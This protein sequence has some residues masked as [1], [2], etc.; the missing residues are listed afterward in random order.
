MSDDAMNTTRG[1][2]PQLPR[3]LE[4]L[5]IFSFLENIADTLLSSTSRFLVLTA[6]TAAGKSTA[7][8][9]IFLDKLPGK[10]LMLE[11]RRVAAL[12]IAERLS[13]LLGQNCGETVGYRMRMDSRVSECTRLEVITEALLTR[14]IQGDP[15]LS[16]V[17]LVILDEFHERSVQGDLAL[18]LLR[19]VASLRDDLYVLI[20]SATIDTDQ[21]SQFLSAPVLT[22][23]GRTWPVE[24]A[25]DGS[26]TVP[27]AVMRELERGPGDLLV[28]LPGLFEIRSA[29]RTLGDLIGSDVELLVLHSSVSLSDQRA[30][31]HGSGNK[32]RV[33]LSSAIAETSLTVPGVT[34][35][36]DSGLS[37]ISRF[38]VRTGMDRLV[39]VPESV[40]SATQRAGR[41]GRTAPGRALRLWDAHDRRP[42]SLSTEIERTDIIPLV[43]D[44]ALWGVTRYDGLQWLTPPQ[45][46]AWEQ[47]VGILHWMGAL[48]NER[49]IT[50]R[51]RTMLNLGVHPRLA[52]VA[53][54]G[55]IEL[56]VAHAGYSENS[57]E[58][59]R[60]RA[61]LQRR[62]QREGH[63]VQQLKTGPGER[64]MALLSGFP[65]RL[66]LHRGDGVY[67]FPS[68]RLAALPTTD[69]RSVAVLPRW[70]VAT[71]VDAGEREG[72]IRTFSE[73][74]TMLCEQWLSDKLERKTEITM[75][76]PA[77]VKTERYYYDRLIVSERRLKVETA[78]RA[79]ALCALLRRDGLKLI[80][81]EKTVQS[82]LQRARFYWHGKKDNPVSENNLLA[83]LEEWL[84]PFLDS[85][86]N[87][88][89]EAQTV[90]QALRYRC[91]GTM[92]DGEVPSRITLANGLSR[93]LEYQEF[94]AD[95]GPVPV[96]E[97]RVQDLFGCPET[98]RVHGRPVLL[99]LLSP[100]RR[101]LQITSDLQGFWKNSWSEVVKE[102]KGRYPRHDWPSD[103]GK[104]QPPLNARKPPSHN[105]GSN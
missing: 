65:D 21:L 87:G 11:P 22:V 40:F 89:P 9:L 7:V 68:G 96:L 28:F 12:A 75:N 46:A 37:R 56:A 14:R 41:A 57:R 27:N 82:F 48:D 58:K 34:V 85:S 35:V 16:G 55:E 8:P 3:E 88:L 45:E 19:E 70:I 51:G 98:P 77:A 71:E 79:A 100:A 95:E 102:M 104:A 5:P 10:I 50:S 97:T 105:P 81:E 4:Q 44:C 17:S 73:L 36:I 43:L 59:E 92:L 1:R 83:S 33:I 94:S 90:L 23:P 6:E 60:F 63:K 69:R 80:F 13:E 31:L 30:V 54:T 32:R 84:V 91:D 20:M 38:D 39:T 52:A 86:G 18:A 66:A 29:E 15:G 61:D 47:A 93:P 49:R 101:P 78:D 62:L 53:L 72:R 24:I 99:R 76:G 103:P 74:D 25:Y 64:A 67:Q 42:D 26:L 2:P